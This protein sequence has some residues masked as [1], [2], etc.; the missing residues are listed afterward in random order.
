MNTDLRS[1]LS[2]A[3]GPM[4]LAPAGGPMPL[5]TNTLRSPS[6]TRSDQAD[7][8]GILGIANRVTP[9]DEGPTHAAQ[10]RQTAEE[11]VSKVFIEPMLAQVRESNQSP[12]P[13]G[14]GDGEKQFAGLIDAQRALE[15]VRSASWPI[16]DRLTSDMLKAVRPTDDATPVA[17]TSL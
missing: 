4:P 5:N 14:P 11:F 10:A 13:F 15:L 7:F 1:I 3:R 16:V 17:R 2:S 9:D 12:P 6:D 8:A